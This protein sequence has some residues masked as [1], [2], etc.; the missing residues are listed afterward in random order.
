M[1]KKKK[2]F[3]VSP[4]GKE[5]SLIRKINDEKFNYI[6]KPV[7]EE[8][9]Y[10]IK[11]ADQINEPGLISQS[12]VNR[13]ISDDLVIVDVTDENPNVFYELC[14]RN[15][16]FK[17]VI[18]IK[19]VNQNLP[20]DTFDK[21]AISINITSLEEAE[22]SKEILKKFVKAAEKDPQSAS[23]SIISKCIICKQIKIEEEIVTLDIDEKTIF[24]IMSE[25]GNSFYKYDF[26]IMI[27]YYKKSLSKLQIISLLDSYGDN[28]GSYFEKKMF[29]KSEL[30]YSTKKNNKITYKLTIE[31]KKYADEIIGRSMSCKKKIN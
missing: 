31:G 13:I 23:E 6:F 26:I 3:V 15:A 16:I 20:F 17:P 2:C 10:E 30:F 14:I 28:W 24:K 22:K 5:G 12:I 7:L 18:L 1:D 4:I 19:N 25:I 27:L 8:L 9:G 11:R 21:R 29:K